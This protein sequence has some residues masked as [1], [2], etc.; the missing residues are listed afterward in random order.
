MQDNNSEADATEE[1]SPIEYEKPQFVEYSVE[2]R[3]QSGKHS[4]DW[5]IYLQLAINC[6]EALQESDLEIMSMSLHRREV[7]R[8]GVNNLS[9]TPFDFTDQ[10]ETP[11]EQYDG[12]PREEIDEDLDRILDQPL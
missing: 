8:W 9:S 11:V 2:Y 1:V 12:V 4:T 7:L 3:L 10:H 6:Y 5:T